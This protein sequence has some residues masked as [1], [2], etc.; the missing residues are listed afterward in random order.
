MNHEERELI[1]WLIHVLETAYIEVFAYNAIFNDRMPGAIAEI[2]YLTRNP[3]HQATV[4]QRFAAALDQSLGP[5]EIKQ[6]LIRA[7]GG[8]KPERPS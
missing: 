8:E 1:E 4:R 5:D 7:L 3:H 2:E 6:A